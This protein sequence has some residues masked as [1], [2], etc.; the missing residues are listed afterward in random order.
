MKKIK[1]IGIVDDD[2]ITVFGIR[3]MLNTVVDCEIV[4]A[5]QNGKV[6]FEALHKKFSEN[7]DIPEVIFLDIN[8]PIMDGWQFLDE[9]LKLPI[10]KRIRINIVTSSIDPFDKKKW[11][12]YKENTHHLITFNNKP[13]NKQDIEEITQ[14]A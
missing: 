6:A 1:F 4:E 14:V 8:M 2:P 3:K 11:E 13:I 10:N 5:Y 7:E 9:F 12:Y